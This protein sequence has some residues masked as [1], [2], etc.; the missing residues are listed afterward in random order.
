MI[1]DSILSLVCS[2]NAQ[3]VQD[4]LRQKFNYD[5]KNSGN[6]PLHALVSSNVTSLIPRPHQVHDHE[7]RIW[8]HYVNFWFCKLSNYVTICI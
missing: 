1:N 8:G 3:I 5:M 4:M 6:F 2:R 7:E